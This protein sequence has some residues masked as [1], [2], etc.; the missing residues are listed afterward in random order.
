M[1]QGTKMTKITGGP[2]ERLRG[3]PDKGTAWPFI[4]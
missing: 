3:P 4:V 2:K 1:T